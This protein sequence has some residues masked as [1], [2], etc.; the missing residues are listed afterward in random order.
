MTAFRASHWFF[1]RL[2]TALVL[3]L[4]L[5]G[6]TFAQ[7]A[8][9]SGSVLEKKEDGKGEAMIGVTVALQG[10]SIGGVTDVDGTYLLPDIPPGTYT[11]TYS[12]VGYVK[13]VYTAIKFVAGEEKKLNVELVET[14]QVIDNAVTIFG[15]R[16]LVDVERGKSTQTIGNDV[17]EAAPQRQIQ[18]LLNTQTGI[19][20]NPEGISIRG[21]RTY[22]TA[23]IVDGVS[24]QDP[25]SGTG[26][27]VDLGTNSLQN[28]DVTTGGGEVEYG[29]GSAGI[30]Q[31]TTRSGGEKFELTLGHKRDNFGF[32]RDWNSV[33]N[34]SVYEASAGGTLFGKG[35]EK[36]RLRAFFS[37]KA[38]F[39]DQYFKHP[40][41]QVISSIY[42]DSLW[43]PTQDNRWSALLKLNYDVSKNIKLSFSYLRSLTVN[44]DVNMLRITG[45]DVQFAPGYQ[46]DFQLQPDN[47]NTYTH[48]SNLETLQLSHNVSTKFFYKIVAS[49]LFVHLRADANG[50]D[51]RPDVVNSEFDPRSIVQYPNTYF[52]PND[53]ITFVNPGPGLYNNGGVAT[54]WHDHFVNEYTLRYTGN[55]YYSMSGVNRLTF[56]TEAK[57]QELQWIDI[58]RP[59]VGAPVPLAN[60]GTT[61]SF[62]LGDISDVWKANPL[63]GAF[64]A[65]NRLKYLG[66][67]AE[68]GGRLEYWFPGS[69]VD[70]AVENQGSPIADQIRKDYKKSTGSIFGHRYKM[71]LLPKIS[72]TFPIKENQVLFFN[73][74]HAMV[75]PHPSFVYTGLDPFYADRSTLSRLGNPNL[76]PEVD[77]SYE[78]G[79]KSQLTSNDALTVAAYWKD[80]YDFITSASLQIPDATGQEVTRT[81]RINSDYARVRG[82]EVTYIKRVGRWYRGQLSGSYSVATGQS[83]SASETL[84]SLLNAGVREDTREL[85]LAWDSPFDL[86]TV[87]TVTYDKPRGFLG[88]KALNHFVFYAE[89][90]YRSGRRYTPYI[91][92]GNEPN[93]GRPI[94]D[95]NPDPNARYSKL[96]SSNYWIDLNLRRWFQVKKVRMEVTLEVTNVFN[97]RND[98]IINPVTGR[99]WQQGDPVPSSQRDPAY[100]DPRDSRS[101]GTPP[102]NPA[103]YR[104]PRHFMLGVNIRL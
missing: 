4:G 9:L 65:S 61:Q 62:R 85:F 63:R 92:T 71:R 48:D 16:P 75:L 21:G 8:S 50:R 82:L 52:N 55:Y 54:L 31:A 102:D 94:Y 11:I 96:G 87:N 27:G 68:V 18:G 103:R 39:D 69:F 100:I 79:V 67:I 76:N 36:N 10:T 15:D 14:D 35:R 32:N 72:A 41:R 80:K 66:L 89:A 73:Y 29:D 97:T 64:Y 104:S 51:W 93:T 12:Y 3:A 20:Q 40:A 2:L 30:V 17:I 47:A 38:A 74:N 57:Q 26:F 7:K 6:T 44:Q 98:I 60:G 45:N 101:S 33:F 43:S 1:G 37:A 25:L 46:F 56:G 24:A 77:I 58:I 34:T 59:W 81:I 23:F 19:V 88:V 90:I 99:A 83:S 13:Q 53:S 70:D 42:P 95:V 49:R 5:S 86:K 28:I 78:L 84:N 91:L 22:E